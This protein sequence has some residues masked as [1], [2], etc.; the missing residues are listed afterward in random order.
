MIA[1]AFG[2]SLGQ[3]D[4]PPGQVISSVL[5]HLTGARFGSL[6]PVG[7]YIVWNQRVPRVFAALVIGAG[8]SIAGVLLQTVVRNPMAEPYLLGVS[9]G[10]ATGAVAMITVGAGLGGLGYQVPLAA[11]LGALAAISLVMLVGRRHG[12]I[13]PGRLLLSGVAIGYLLQGVTSYLQIR[14]TPAELGA[15][16][17]WLL[18]SLAGV[19][20]RQT[21]LAAI[22]IAAGFGWAMM[23]A[24]FANSLL[25]DDDSATAL[26][27]QVTR[28][29][30]ELLIVSALA[31]GV[32]VALAGGVGFVGLMVPHVVR[33][34]IGGDHRK[35][36]PGAV[37]VGALLVT[38]VDTAGRMASESELPLGIF[39]A[40]IGVPFLL[41][42][43]RRDPGSGR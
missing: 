30:I 27:A 33:L 39:T 7:D 36:L 9:A 43:V 17:F 10:A 5:N 35:L 25:L 31:T 23:R 37:L 8:L 24:R 42:L 12:V 13:A 40:F 11:F 32:C 15:V 18:G 41:W 34:L 29:R 2:I 3:A 20:A 4:L 38:V 28:L 6:D 14:A 16:M 21:G 1:V 26:G 19:D 22:V